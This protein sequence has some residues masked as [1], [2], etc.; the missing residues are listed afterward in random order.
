MS[1]VQVQDSS[2]DLIQ[3][4]EVWEGKTL[5]WELEKASI[6]IPNACRTGMCGACMCNIISWEASVIKNFKGEPAFP[7]WDD[8]VMTCIAW[9]KE[10][11]TQIIL[12]TIN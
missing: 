5:L 6:E 11:E 4:L 8:E 7:L 3:A 10:S 9:I 2:W 1:Q 12:Q